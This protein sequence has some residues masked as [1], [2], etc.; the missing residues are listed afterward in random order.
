VR[1]DKRPIL[2]DLRGSG[3]IEEDGDI[4]LFVYQ[5][6]LYNPNTVIPNTLEIGIGKN[7]DGPLERVLADLDLSTSSIINL[8]PEEAA[9]R[10]KRYE[11]SLKHRS[12]SKKR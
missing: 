4:I 2:S 5:D 11:A 3:A 8:T 6:R 9:E 10:L 1:E 7:R 12:P